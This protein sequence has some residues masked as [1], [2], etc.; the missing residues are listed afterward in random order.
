MSVDQTGVVD[1]IGVNDSSGEVVLT[2]TDHLEWGNN[3]HLLLLQEKLNTYLG[4]VESGEI[5][6]TY[7]D[8]NGRG[9]LINVVC[10]Y[11]PDESAVSFFNQVSSVVE[12]TEQF[13]WQLLFNK[14]FE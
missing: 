7:A 14:I 11:P 4:F 2:I 9:V 3:E 1:A 6:N 8:A 10:K 12:G 5:L 13:V